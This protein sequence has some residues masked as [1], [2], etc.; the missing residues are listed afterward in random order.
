M[1]SLT[2]IELRRGTKVLLTE[3]ELVI[4]PGQH[5]GIIGANGC[6]KSSLF[7]LLLGQVAPDAGNLFIPRDW[8]IAH[9]AQEL[10]TSENSAVDFVLDGDVELRRAEAAIEKALLD[11]DNN[12][13]ANEYEKMD[14]MG[15]FDAHYRA[16]FSSI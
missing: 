16:G 14:T 9:M 6:G 11:E 1:I 12:R 2:D 4:H 10:A 7:K 15:G 13:L 5:I 8:R 3:A